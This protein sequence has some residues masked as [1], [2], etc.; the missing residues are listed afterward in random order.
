[1]DLSNYCDEKETEWNNIEENNANKIIEYINS[2][3]DK[4][5]YELAKTNNNIEVYK[6]LRI[7]L[8]DYY[9]KELYDGLSIINITKEDF[10]KSIIYS[11]ILSITRKTSNLEFLINVYKKNNIIK[12]LR[13]YEEI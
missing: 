9:K 7:W 10:Y 5:L 13:E 1:M 11:L 12:D 3:I 4:N 8:L 6:K 2:K